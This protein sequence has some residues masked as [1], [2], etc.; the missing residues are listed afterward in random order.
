MARGD[1]AES[2]TIGQAL[3]SCRFSTDVNNLLVWHDM[4]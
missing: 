2:E 1:K 4:A 3:Y